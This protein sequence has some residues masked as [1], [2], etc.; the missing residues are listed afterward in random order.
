MNK[1]RWQYIKNLS[2]AP[3]RW[4]HVSCEARIVNMRDP[5]TGVA[6]PAPWTSHGVVYNVGRNRAKRAA[7]A[8]LRGR[9]SCPT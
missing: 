9:V 8:D 3:A 1:K 7:A 5:K 4:L 6:R 2:T